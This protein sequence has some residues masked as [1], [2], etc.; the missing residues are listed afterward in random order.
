MSKNHKTQPR[1]A[2][3]TIRLGEERK[4]RIE[5]FRAVRRANGEVISTIDDA[6]NIL[7]DRG[8]EAENA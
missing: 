6:V 7:V 8:L 2:A 3:H 1:K 4:E 5:R